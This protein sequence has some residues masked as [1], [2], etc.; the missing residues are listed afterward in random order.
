M[1]GE[2][3]SQQLCSPSD[4]WLLTGFYTVITCLSCLLLLITFPLSVWCLLKVVPD[5]QRIVVFRLGRVRPPRGPGLVLLLPLIDQFQRVDMRTN[6]FNIPPNKMKSRDGAVV[7]IGADIQFR[8]SDPVLSVMSVQ[9]LSFVIR[10]TAQ[11]LLVQSLDR[12][13]LREICTDK[14]RIGEHLKEDISEQVKPWGVCIERA[15]LTM[16]AIFQSPESGMESPVSTHSTAPIGGVEQLV[17]QVI[18]LAQQNMEE[19]SPPAGLPLEHL[20]TRLE[21]N[22]TEALVSDVKSS[23]QFYL[24]RSDGERA[25]YFLDLTSGR[26]RAGWGLLDRFPDVTLEISE[27]DLLSLMQG[28]LHPLTAYTRGRLRVGGNLQT[29]LKLEKVLQVAKQ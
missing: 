19:T 18:S 4:S 17:M 16:E 5:Y 11:N 15:E 21:G 28:D 26:G 1:L 8:V 25:P 22:L 29:A 10:N 14:L 13:Y 20:L 2:G 24:S 23:F 27:A 3:T 12:K 9:D 6:A 7:S